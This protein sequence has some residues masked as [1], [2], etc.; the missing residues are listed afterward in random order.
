[1]QQKMMDHFGLLKEETLAFGDGNN[2]LEMIKHVGVGVAM[3]NGSEALKDV[4]DMVTDSVDED[5]VWNALKKL[6]LV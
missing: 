5:G 2:D 1:M 4:A 3:G 6:G